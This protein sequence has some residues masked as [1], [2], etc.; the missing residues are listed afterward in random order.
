MTHEEGRVEAEV[1]SYYRDVQ[2]AFSARDPQ[3]L[4]ALFDPAIT[5]PMTHGQILDWG[6]KF[7][8]ENS[9]VRFHIDKLDVRDLGPGR[10]VVNLRYHVTTKD[11][12]AD[13]GGAEIDT[14]VRRGGK[15]LMTEWE[16]VP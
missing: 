5:Q 16:K 15:W 11:N 4:A 6:R 13:F 8:G 14:L 2:K 12:K 9:E 3:A 10:A 1:R 7:Y